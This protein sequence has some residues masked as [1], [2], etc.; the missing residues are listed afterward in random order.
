MMGRRRAPGSVGLAALRAA[1]ASAGAAMGRPPLMRI[2]CALLAGHLGAYRLT[3]AAGSLSCS[4]SAALTADLTQ[5][6]HLP[7]AFPPCCFAQLG[8]GG[9]CLVSGRDGHEYEV[10]DPRKLRWA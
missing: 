3:R 9:C 6:L 10:E 1:A 2:W 4:S 7:G 5:L 8:Q